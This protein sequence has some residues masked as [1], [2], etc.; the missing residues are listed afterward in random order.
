MEGNRNSR[1]ARLE[2]SRV[3]Y[4]AAAENLQGVLVSPLETPE[5][6]HR[7]RRE[8]FRVL[9]ALNAAELELEELK[10]KQGT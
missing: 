2:H 10:T 9:E 1:I 8:L 4:K 3:F 6:R 7:A 5:S